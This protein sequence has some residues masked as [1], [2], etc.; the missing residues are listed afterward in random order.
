MSDQSPNELVRD[1]IEVIDER[2]QYLEGYPRRD[3]SHEQRLD[4]RIGE[5]EI[6][7]M[8]MTGGGPDV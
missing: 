8:R 4:D 1:P 3:K 7:K 2:I 5:L 6:V